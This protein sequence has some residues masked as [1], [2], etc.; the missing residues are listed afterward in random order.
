MTS[1]IHPDA[2]KVNEFYRLRGGWESIAD[3]KN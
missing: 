1:Y 2:E 3:N